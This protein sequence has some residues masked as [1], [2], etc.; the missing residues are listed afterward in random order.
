VAIRR[1]NYGRRVVPEAED[2][3]IGPSFPDHVSGS[4]RWLRH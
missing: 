3:Q 1:G 4:K 2:G